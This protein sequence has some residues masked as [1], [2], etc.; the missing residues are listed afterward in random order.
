MVDGELSTFRTAPPVE[1]GKFTITEVVSDV[2][3]HF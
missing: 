2:V 1:V 3:V